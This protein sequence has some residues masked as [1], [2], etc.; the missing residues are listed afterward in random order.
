MSDKGAEMAEQPD[1]VVA[2]DDEQVLDMAAMRKVR[3]EAAS[4]RRDR[5]GLR[6]RVHELEEQ[7]GAAA[8]REAASQRRDAE[9]VAG[10]ILHDPTDIWRVSAEVQQSFYDEQFG[11]ITADNIVAAAKQLASEKPHLARPPSGPPPSQRPIETL[12]PGAS[13]QDTPPPATW[14][15]AI[16]GG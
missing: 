16:R 13:Q 6:T 3:H 12:R 8:A 14:H 7:L 2:D 9:R 11:D 4:L 10:E 5:D 15:T 1:E